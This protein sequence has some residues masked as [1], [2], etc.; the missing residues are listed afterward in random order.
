MENSKDQ[1][2][3]IQQSK[4]HQKSSTPNKSYSVPRKYDK[5]IHKTTQI[6]RISIQRLIEK[7]DQDN[8]GWIKKDDILVFSKKHYLFFEDELAQAMIDE[9]IS[10][11][12][13]AFKDQ[14]KEPINIDEVLGAV[15]LHYVLNQD[16]I[17]VEK[18]RPYR[19]HWIQLLLAAGE[20]LPSN[21]DLPPVK[22]SK[23]LDMH[24]M[25]PFPFKPKLNSSQSQIIHT[26]ELQEPRQFPEQQPEAG[27]LLQETIMIKPINNGITKEQGTDN[28]FE[29][30]VNSKF[31]NNDQQQSYPTLRFE[32]QA[33]Y[34]EAER[35]SKEPKLCKSSRNPI[36]KF[37]PE[38]L[39][40]KV[41]K[42]NSQ[43][44]SQ[45]QNQT[46]QLG[47]TAT[48]YLSQPVLMRKPYHGLS[49]T[50]FQT[51]DSKYFQPNQNKKQLHEDQNADKHIFYATFK[52]EDVQTLKNKLANLKQREKEKLQDFYNPPSTHKFRDDVLDKKKPL[53]KTRIKPDPLTNPHMMSEHDQRPQ[54]AIEEDEKKQ[55]RE[56]QKQQ[57]YID[58]CMGTHKQTKQ[59]IKYFPTAD[60]NHNFV[61]HKRP[62]FIDKGNYQEPGLILF[63][64][65]REGASA[66]DDFQLFHRQL[67]TNDKHLYLGIQMDPNQQ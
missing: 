34:N 63:Q 58:D 38:N 4:L 27:I 60:L 45:D 37:M 7:M 11:R 47:Q 41:D 56:E 14:L 52:P 59:W 18:S 39:N 44:Q 30:V 67:R 48:K 17:W 24:E 49:D 36:F 16:H 3:D 19:D 55:M 54:F 15:Q 29:K 5:L 6:P 43:K 8:D 66:K 9:A 1:F 64:F 53:F 2:G 42:M 12:I 23:V 61:D 31:N 13:V 46:Q 51:S 21:H 10:K 26:S 33:Y 62:N 25:E 20:K 57:D 28:P 22:I 35:L 40:Y 65:L 32:T 50:G